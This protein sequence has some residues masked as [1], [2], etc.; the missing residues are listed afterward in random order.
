MLWC[1]ER[2][3]FISLYTLR[4]WVR[5]RIRKPGEFEMF[6][7]VKDAQVGSDR[8]QRYLLEAEH[9]RLVRASQPARNWNLLGSLGGALIRLA[10]LLV[11]DGSDTSFYSDSYQTGVGD[12]RS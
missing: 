7:Y 9:E 1:S 3:N 5:E 11:S 8:Y 10:S 2:K 6:N 4:A 12:A